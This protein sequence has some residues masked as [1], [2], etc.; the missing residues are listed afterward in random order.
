MVA[1]NIGSW[2]QDGKREVGYWLGQAFW[3]RGIATATLAAFLHLV[4]ERPLY[5]WVAAHNSASLRV[6][7]KCGF[8]VIGTD[9]KESATG[10]EA[11]GV[12]LVLGTD[13]PGDTHETQVVP[14]N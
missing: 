2:V 1:G 7:K 9:G 5:A 8:H 6:L 10:A 12:I 4:T 14:G 13:A 3:G 11:E